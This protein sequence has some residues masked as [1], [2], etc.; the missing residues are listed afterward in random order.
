MG[1]FGIFQPR[2]RANDGLGHGGDGLVLT[3]HA[4]VQF[5]VQVQEFLHL[6]F[7]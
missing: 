7:E 2:A 5:L 4:L 3:N 1:R 6:A